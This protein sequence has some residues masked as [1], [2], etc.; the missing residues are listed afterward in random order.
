MRQENAYI[1]LAN[2][3]ARAKRMPAVYTNEKIA[4]VLKG[5]QSGDYNHLLKVLKEN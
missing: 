1:L 2:W 3:R 5:A 4:S